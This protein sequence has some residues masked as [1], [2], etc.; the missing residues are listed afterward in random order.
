ML[1]LQLNRQLFY[2]HHLWIMCCFL[3]FFYFFNKFC[4]NLLNGGIHKDRAPTKDS[5]LRWTCPLPSDRAIRTCSMAEFRIKR[6]YAHS[7]ARPVPS[8]TSPGYG[9]PP[10]VAIPARRPI[11][12]KRPSRFEPRTFVTGTRALTTRS[13]T[14]YRLIY[15]DRQI[16][17][18][19]LPRFI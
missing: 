10:T 13:P 7:R 1:S 6:T 8:L 18:T 3:L 17:Y 9:L 15:W 12:T 4:P 14:L 2:L 5:L 19:H 11:N 16:S